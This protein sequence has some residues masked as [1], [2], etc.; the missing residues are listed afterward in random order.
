MRCGAFETPQFAPDSQ[1][2]SLGALSEISVGMRGRVDVVAARLAHQVSGARWAGDRA[3]ARSAAAEAADKVS[4]SVAKYQDSPK[5]G[6][7]CRGCKFYIPS[8]GH[9]GAGMM[10]GNM[11]AGMMAAG[12]SSLSREALAH[13]VGAFSTSPFHA[14]RRNSL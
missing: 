13:G 2:S 10:G 14:D 12:A 8:G 6:Q 7:I 4:K 3:S 1:A 5:D 11:G 9:A